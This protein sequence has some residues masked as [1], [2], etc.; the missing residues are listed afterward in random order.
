MRVSVKTVGTGE[1]VG[2]IWSQGDA[3]ILARPDGIITLTR[4][5]LDAF[6]GASAG[7]IVGAMDGW[8]NGYIS[9]N[10]VEDVPAA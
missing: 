6:P 2:E 4:R 8:S 3:T 9:C 10:R 7:V 1:Q 5:F